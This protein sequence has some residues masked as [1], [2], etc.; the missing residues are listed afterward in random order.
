MISVRKAKEFDIANMVAL[1]YEKRKM[2]EKAQPQFWKYAESAESSQAKWFEELLNRDDYILL[3]AEYQNASEQVCDNIIRGFIIGR[4]IEAPEVY[5]PGGLTTMIDDFCVVKPD[6]WEAV[7]RELI[8]VIKKL[9][10]DKG[11]RQIVVVCGVHDE[12]KRQFLKNI[13]LTVASEWYVGNIT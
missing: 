1:S 11:A 4:I 3:V 5:D 9:S 10:K 6:L 13:P 12:L 7:G 8:L 2:Y